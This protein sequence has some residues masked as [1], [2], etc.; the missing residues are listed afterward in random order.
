MLSV[1][2]IA[3]VADCTC[4]LKVAVR[5]TPVPTPIAPAVGLVAVTVGGVVSGA[6]LCSPEYWVGQVRGAVRFG[7]AVGVLR[8]RGVG[9]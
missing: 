8:E 9:A 2:V 1:T 7:A 4:S 3:T 6:E 5:P